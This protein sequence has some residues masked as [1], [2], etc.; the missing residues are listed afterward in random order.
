MAAM[1]D[2]PA[3]SCRITFRL[4]A[5]QVGRLTALAGYL[6]QPRSE[7]LR[8]A[9]ALLDA[10]ATSVA[11]RSRQRP[12][13]DELRAEARRQTEEIERTLQAERPLPFTS[14]RA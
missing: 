4:P 11:L 12:G 5:E 14:K 3:R 9:V 7:V 13:T 1:S 10:R 2:R 8:L 6:G